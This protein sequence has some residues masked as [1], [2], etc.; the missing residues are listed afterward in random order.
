MRNK[1]ILKVLSILLLMAITAVGTRIFTI[2]QIVAGSSDR[3]AKIAM[4]ENY[5][6][7]NAL[8]KVSDKDF[9]IGELKGV[10]S[11]LKDP[12]SEY[13][14]KEEMD[15]LRES[16]TGKF[17]GIGVYISS[18]EDGIITVV[19]PI[20]GSPADK[21]NIKSGDKILKINDKEFSGEK[22][23]EASNE[24]KGQKGTEVKLLLLPK[25]SK[26]AN[27]SKNLREV[28]V[29]RDEVKIE[30]IIK[31]SIGDIGYIGI[32]VFDEDTGVDFKKAL[33][34]VLAENKKGL[35]LDLRG[36]PGGL[37]D[38]CIEIA[39]ELIKE[40]PIVTLKD[41]DKKIV[42]E[43]KADKKY[44]DIPLVV[45]INGGSASASEILA[46]AIKDTERAKIVGEKS[47]GKG[48]VQG[49]NA[50][51]DGS[52]IKLTT[53]E[54]FTPKGISIHEKGIVPDFVIKEPENI[55]GI[56]LEFKDTDTQLKKA[57]EIL[58][59]TH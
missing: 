33:G 49:V 24:I 25:D 4:L 57:I 15:R 40:G 5:I 31:G 26:D 56:G 21:A 10:V 58:K 47:F 23:S 32:T 42:S 37:I 52:G 44:T 11:A 6:R 54:Y 7:K 59:E 18:G 13:L 17:F 50:L 34:E 43:Y 27:T 51:S 35:I 16:T 36:N 28:V 2:R 38:S 30:T 55:K 41:R 9:E 29:K 1:K 53:S 3:F 20:K 45:L 14:T 19:S 46:G 12:Y 22:I 48:V 8:Y 39:D